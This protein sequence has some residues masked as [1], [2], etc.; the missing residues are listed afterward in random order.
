MQ[1]ERIGFRVGTSDGTHEACQTIE[2]LLELLH[3]GVSRTP[4]RG[5]IGVQDEI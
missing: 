1:S 3:F 4:S 5:L 2:M